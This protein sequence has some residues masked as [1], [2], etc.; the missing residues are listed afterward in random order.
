MDG[1]ICDQV[2]SILIDSGYNYSYVSS[3]LVDKCGL[4]IEVHA[5][6]CLVQLATGTK[7]R[8]H[9]WV[10]AC[11]FGHNGISTLAHL[12]VLLLG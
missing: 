8:V 5:K 10:R 1:K 6:S 3:E 12:N 2:V 7:K 11:A 4:N 9:H